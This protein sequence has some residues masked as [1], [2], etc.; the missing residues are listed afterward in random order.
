MCKYVRICNEPNSAL[1][2]CFQ[3]DDDFGSSL[4]QLSE[5]FNHIPCARLEA[6]LSDYKDEDSLCP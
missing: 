4:V 5:H 6:R 3:F 1:K 2:K